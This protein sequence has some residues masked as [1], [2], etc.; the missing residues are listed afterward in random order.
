MLLLVA[1]DLLLA[2]RALPHTQPTAPQAVYDL[3][4]AP[5]HLLTDPL[6][7]DLHPAA[8]GRFLSMSS[9]TFDPGDMADYAH[10]LRAE[11]APQ[12][13][14]RAFDQLILALKA[15]EILAPNLA[16][17][18]RIPSLDGFDGGVLPLARY[19][20][21][22][23]LF[24]PIEQRIDDGRVREQVQATPPAD[25]LALYNVQYL[26]TDK[27][28]DLWY[29]GIYYDRQ[30]GARLGPD[31]PIVSVDAPHPFA[32]THLHLIVAAEDDP[33]GE[34]ADPAAPWL[35]VTMTGQT[36]AG[37][38]TTATLTVTGT[39][40]G[41]SALD[42]PLPAT[43]GPQIAYRDV[44]GERQEY[45]VAM[46]LPE[47][48]T[49]TTL[50]VTWQADAPP[51]SVQAATLVDARTG[52][53]RAL[54]PSDRGRYRLVHSGDVKLYE[55]LD[56]L[57]RAYLVHTVHAAATADDAVTQVAAQVAGE[58]FDLRHAAVVEGLPGFTGEA[59]AGDGATVRHYSPESVTVHT[60]SATAALLVLADTFDPGWRATV[61]GVPV[62]IY[63]TNV[64]LRGVP[65]PAGEHTVTFV[66]AP[67]AWQQ[68]LGVGLVGLLLLAGLWMFA[69]IGGP[70]AHDV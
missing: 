8:A 45:L 21:L 23:T 11:A 31:R 15:Q 28:R 62:S 17:L 59:A 56:V 43:G 33:A 50:T 26:I 58:G 1:L 18:W 29:A 19:L 61:D 7:R 44:E 64:L 2:A 67:V 38:P 57:P 47:I 70:R 60:T 39:V 52:M 4:T 51:I 54:L 10:I 37:A 22:L 40:I 66:Y 25:L 53:F 27:V 34:Y 9:L 41:P 63:R 24:V 35:E 20:D 30:I 68:G 42:A 12:L 65:V 14:S 55:N 36:A 48:Q 49:P 16:L 13:D 6:R 69:W 3:R 32:A 46:E 5:A